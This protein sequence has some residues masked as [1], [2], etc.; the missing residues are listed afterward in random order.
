MLLYISNPSKVTGEHAQ[1]GRADVGIHI[2]YIAL[3]SIHMYTWDKGQRKWFGVDAKLAS[4]LQRCR[5]G[6]DALIGTSKTFQ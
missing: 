3:M 4:L 6:V 1:S 5:I 2:G